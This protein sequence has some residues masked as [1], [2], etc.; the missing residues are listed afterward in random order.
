MKY[1]PV[2]G[3]SLSAEVGF[4]PWAAGVLLQP[5]AE[6]TTGTTADFRAGLISA[7]DLSFGVEWL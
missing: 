4:S 6:T 7:V 5:P 1:F 3:W 2:R